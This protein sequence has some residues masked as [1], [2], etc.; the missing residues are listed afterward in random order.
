MYVLTVTCLGQSALGV[1]HIALRVWEAMTQST[2]VTMHNNH[3]NFLL[4][5]LHYQ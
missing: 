3:F 1:M 2:A 5:H 4:C